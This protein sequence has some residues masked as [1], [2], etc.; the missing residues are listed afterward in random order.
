MSVSNF[1]IKFK[2]K[3]KKGK[4]SKK[5]INCKKIM[6]RKKNNNNMKK[7]GLNTY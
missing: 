7:E 6:D 2:N 4:L 5:H 1:M 3:Q